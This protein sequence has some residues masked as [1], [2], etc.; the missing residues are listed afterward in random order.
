MTDTT[1]RDQYLALILPL[2]LRTVR[3]S[4][5]RDATAQRQHLKEAWPSLRQANWLGE[6]AARA[7]TV[8]DIVDHLNK[9]GK[10]W[11]DASEEAAKKRG[12]RP[13]LHEV[14][15]QQIG[16]NLDKQVRSAFDRGMSELQNLKL[17]P[18]HDTYRPGAAWVQQERLILARQYIGDL[19]AWYRIDHMPEEKQ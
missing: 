17:A 16:D 19:I 3:E 15:A 1:T 2:H 14:I 8:Q 6:V 4:L 11:A 7:R 13:A 18:A 9:Q 5:Q 10:R 12:G